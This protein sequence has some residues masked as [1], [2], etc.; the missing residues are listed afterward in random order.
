MGHQ[1]HHHQVSSGLLPPATTS[2]WSGR[3][4]QN[5]HPPTAISRS[6]ATVNDLTGEHHVALVKGEIGDGENVLCRVHSEC[7]TGDVFASTRC[8]CGDQLRRHGTDRTRKAGRAALYASGRPRHRSDQQAEAYE[9]QEQGLTLWKPTSS[10]ALPLICGILG[11]R[12]DP[13]GFGREGLRLLTNNPSKIYGLSGFGLQI[14][15]GSRSRSG[16]K[17][18]TG[19]I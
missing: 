8:D 10:W 9:L 2:M 6:T 18:M 12:P 7:L 3:P 1:D 5:A 11:W 13:A 4:G 15:G 14:T 16:R 17:S 19:S